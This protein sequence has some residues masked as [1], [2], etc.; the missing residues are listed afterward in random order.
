DDRNELDA[1]AG[2]LIRAMGR[3]LSGF[4]ANNLIGHLRQGTPENT[5]RATAYIRE[6]GYGGTHFARVIKSISFVHALYTV[7]ESLR[8]GVDGGQTGIAGVSRMLSS[9][10][11]FATM[12]GPTFALL[13]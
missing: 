2:T 11:A 13:G 6:H 5:A 3:N 1:T 10:A 8:E 7:S 9:G 4:D 12:A